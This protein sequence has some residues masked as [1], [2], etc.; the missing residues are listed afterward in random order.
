MPNALKGLVSGRKI[1]TRLTSGFALIVALMLGVA[2]IGVS[3]LRSLNADLK[4]IVENRYSKTEQLHTIIE[5]VNAVSI[6]V[7]DALLADWP[8]GRR[9]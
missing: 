5:E 7:R 4:W 9:T 1:G 6:A 3:G 8:P 2:V